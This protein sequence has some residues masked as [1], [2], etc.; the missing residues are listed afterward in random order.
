MLQTTTDCCITY[1]E[2]FCHSA[3]QAVDSNSTAGVWKAESFNSLPTCGVADLERKAS[4]IMQALT[5]CSEGAAKFTRARPC[6]MQCPTQ[7]NGNNCGMCV[8]G[9]ALAIALGCSISDVPV[10]YPPQLRRK[11]A[12]CIQNAVQRQGCAM[13][14]RHYLSA[15]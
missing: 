6:P 15:V 14:D 12:A 11:W 9:M 1:L 3:L 7:V 4:L 10:D 2:H 8:G 5:A 13:L